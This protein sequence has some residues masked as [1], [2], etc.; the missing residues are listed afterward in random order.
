MSEQPTPQEEADRIRLKRLAKLGGSA[1]SSPAPSNPTANAS[2]SSTPHP[3]LQAPVQKPAPRPQPVQPVPTPVSTPTK[4]AN[5]V[6]APVALTNRAAWEEGLVETVFLVT[7]DREKGVRM[8]YK[9]LW[10]KSLKEDL[11]SERAEVH[12]S[13]QIVDSVLISRLEVDPKTPSADPSYQ[14]FL[15]HISPKTTVFEYL[16]GCWR[17]LVLA[18]RSLPKKY[19]AE[20]VSAVQ[21]TLDKLRD[22]IISY[23]GLNMQDPTMFPQP[24]GTTG[25]SLELYESLLSLNSSSHPFASTSTQAGLVNIDEFPLFLTDL[26]RRFQT[27]DEDVLDEILGPVV[28]L[29]TFSSWL[30]RPEGLASGDNGWRSIVTGLEALMSNKGIAKMVTKL[31]EWC[32]E[33]A[34][35]SSFERSSLLGPLIRLGVFQREWPTISKTYFSEPEKRTRADVDASNTSL[36]ATLHN[37]QTSLFQLFNS[38]VRASPESRESVLEYFSKVISLNV[39]RRGLQVDFATV[40]SDGFMVNLQAVLLQFAEPFID[41]KFSKLDRIDPKFFGRSSRISMAEETRVNATSD[42]ASR[43]AEE[44]Q[45]ESQGPANFITEIFYL[46]ATINHYGLMRTI[47][48][49]QDLHKAIDER[50]NVIDRYEGDPTWREQPM[51]RIKDE[52]QLIHEEMFAYQVQL[53]D[54]E[55]SARQLAFNGFLSTWLINLVDPSK[56]HP[57]ITIELPLPQEIPTVFKMIPEFFIEDIADYALYLMRLKP[58]AIEKPARVEILN[59]CFTFLSSTWYIK[60]P[61]LKTRLVQV[62]FYGTLG[63]GREREGILT[64]LLNSHPLS[65]KHL[66]SILTGFYIEV[67]ST[68]SHTQ[69][70]DKFSARDIAYILKAVWNNP[71]HR[72]ALKRES[73]NLDKFVRFINLMMNDVTFLLDESVSKLTEIH[74]IEIEMA[75]PDWEGKPLRHKQERIQTLSSIGQQATSWSALGKSTVDLLKKFTHETKTPFMTPE[76]VDRLAAMLNYNLDALVGP[77]CQDLKVKDMDKYQFN[78]RQLLSDILQVY[79]NLSGEGTFVQAIAG[80]GRSYKKELFERAAG[81]AK[82]RGLKTD[83][84]IEQLRLFVV[85][86]EETRATLQAEDDLGEIP[87]EYLDPLMYTVM[88]DPVIL[89]S[90]RTVI[91]RSTIKAHLLSDTTD[92]FNRVPLKLEDVVPDHE[93]KAKI[94][95]FLAERRRKGGALDVAPEDVMQIDE[96]ADAMHM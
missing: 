63:Y 58:D 14:P 49:A 51:K 20:D 96:N 60:N 87:D 82:K 31:E 47:Q 3:P 92:P 90:S 11:E 77:K 79:I 36:R 74:N 95:G 75:A 70:Y 85:K 15:D 33:N 16:F 8:G 44:V 59:L 37:L 13:A 45:S 7:I 64:E 27:A 5:V 32:P 66:M 54:P 19:R 38:I 78:P 62:M 55:F 18:R 52:M 26:Q 4:K 80:E 73:L 61:F 12:L 10:L 84:E 86:V 40:A 22:L 94:E 68:G 93:L 56:N 2:T 43:W 71:A 1:S 69:F 53:L 88:R 39:K 34:S 83:M 29:L 17:R 6:Q 28:R 76:I 65:L 9:L 89:P 46:T 67:E 72:D 24:E 57:T 42:E 25:G 48:S 41:S 35:A 23:I 91:D 30:A 81:I 21:P 50:Q